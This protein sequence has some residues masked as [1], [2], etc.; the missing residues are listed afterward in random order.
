MSIGFSGALTEM[1]LARG[2]ES[3]ATANNPG[4]A[5]LG[6]I[7]L[8][9]HFLAGGGAALT[10]AGTGVWVCCF[11]SSTLR[12]SVVIPGTSSS[13]RGSTSLISWRGSLTDLAVA[14]SARN[15]PV[16]VTL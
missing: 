16:I 15:G 10:C 2:A 11:S 3:A 13:G 1:Q 5:I 6:I 12:T 7:I 14:I 4:R 8:I 9:S